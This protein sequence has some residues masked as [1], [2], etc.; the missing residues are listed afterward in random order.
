M[1]QSEVKENA[2]GWL[3]WLAGWT[4]WLIAIL[5]LW[6]ASLL[7]GWTGWLSG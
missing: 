1:E 6:L 4:G 5:A 7:A 3:D 2:V